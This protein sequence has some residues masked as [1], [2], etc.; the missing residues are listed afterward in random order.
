MIR[1]KKVLPDLRGSSISSNDLDFRSAVPTRAN[2]EKK[3]TLPVKKITNSYVILEDLLCR[4]AIIVSSNYLSSTN[5]S[6]GPDQDLSLP[7]PIPTLSSKKIVGKKSKTFK[8]QNSLAC[9][10]PS[11][12]KP[13]FFFYCTKNWWSFYFCK[14]TM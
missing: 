5:P 10:L 12:D 3:L 7:F 13:F 2:L 4:H 6:P 14:N 9:A 11:C 1:L 8:L